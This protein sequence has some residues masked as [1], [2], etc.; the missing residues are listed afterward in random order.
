MKIGGGTLKAPAWLIDSDRQGDGV[1]N[2]CWDQNYCGEVWMRPCIYLPADV[3]VPGIDDG[4]LPR[5]LFI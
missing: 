5:L 2:L 1:L 4:D 3:G